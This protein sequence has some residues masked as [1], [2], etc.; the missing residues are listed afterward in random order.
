VEDIARCIV[1]KKEKKVCCNSSFTKNADGSLTHKDPV[2]FDCCKRYVDVIWD[3]KI[4]SGE[5]YIRGS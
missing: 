5:I 4:Q 1:C 3:G 2:C